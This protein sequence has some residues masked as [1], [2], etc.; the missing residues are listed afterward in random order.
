MK[1]FVKAVGGCALALVL[2][3]CGPERMYSWGQYDDAMYQYAQDVNEQADFQKA[4]LD[5]I[6]TNETAGKKVPPG[7][8]AEYG[9]QMLEGG[10]VKDAVKFFEME[11]TEWPEAI[12]FMDTMIAYANGGG[13]VKSSSEAAKQAE[14]K[15]GQEQKVAV[16]RRATE[17]AQ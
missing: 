16:E 10:R 2:T 4:L 5:I 3:A 8:Y 1:S 11:K 12:A 7:V 6:Q 15:S 17:A 13:S 9:Y 14:L